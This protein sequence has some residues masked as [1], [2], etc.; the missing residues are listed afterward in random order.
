VSVCCAAVGSL[1][2]SGAVVAWTEAPLASQVLVH[3]LNI[4]SSAAR[5]GALE[6][7]ELEPH[8]RIPI[9]Q[10]H[11]RVASLSLVA[12][13]VAAAA[14]P[15]STRAT[16][17]PD[18]V[19][20]LLLLASADTGQESR[21]LSLWLPEGST[22][23]ET[24]GAAVWRQVWQTEAFKAVRA[25]DETV[26]VSCNGQVALLGCGASQYRLAR[27][28]RIASFRMADDN[29]SVVVAHTLALPSASVGQPADDSQRA[30]RPRPLE[31]AAWA[32]TSAG[33]SPHGALVAL[34]GRSQPTTLEPH[35]RGAAA[36]L[37]M[38][39]VGP[40]VY[41][42]DWLE[43]VKQYLPERSADPW[44]LITCLGSQPREQRNATAAAVGKAISRQ[45]EAL[46]SPNE[47]PSK[48]AE[49]VNS[50]IALV[51]PRLVA[52]LAALYGIVRRSTPLQPAAP[53]DGAVAEV[54][55]AIA[56]LA[57]AWRAHLMLWISAELLK[58]EI[59]AEI[60]AHAVAEL[61]AASSI[62]PLPNWVR[63]CEASVQTRAG[64]EA[65]PATPR[66]TLLRACCCFLICCRVWK[67]YC[68]ATAHP[69]LSRFGSLPRSLP[70]VVAIAL[71][72]AISILLIAG[73]T[74]STEAPHQ[75]DPSRLEA[76]Y[77]EIAEVQNRLA[78]SQD[79]APEDNHQEA[80]TATASSQ[81]E[82]IR[83]EP[84]L[85]QWEML[86]LERLLQ[87]STASGDTSSYARDVAL[88]SD[89]IRSAYRLVLVGYWRLLRWAGDV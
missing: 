88:V 35:G 2:E 6:Q 14:A 81:E 7:L 4:P 13:F 49:R 54:E 65:L 80:A 23:D 41:K 72:R 10:P 16:Q 71:P 45:L 77:A 28:P 85:L 73:Q 26:D 82:S 86:C 51:G 53:T 70:P 5:L 32:C 67:R 42:E 29:E 66:N 39:H 30:K 25:H 61:P 12:Q 64:F 11:S 56:K 38:V 78:R 87:L 89:Q 18:G 50:K 33:L 59:E 19:G 58:R 40:L 52:M 1:G 75:M 22:C 83:K 79:G 47:V 62:S 55:A 68:D 17:E 74:R 46:L 9:D 15:I 20:L 36:V 48:Q 8:L 63:I 43:T 21:Q 31:A 37:R 44:D 27:L 34:L 3:R 60:G 69:Q 84:P 24:D 57:G 76:V